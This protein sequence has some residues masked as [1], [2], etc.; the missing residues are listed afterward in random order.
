MKLVDYRPGGAEGK[1]LL[2]VA[3]ALQCAVL[4]AVGC[5]P[6]KCNAFGFRAFAGKTIFDRVGAVKTE[7]TNNFLREACELIE[8]WPSELR[9]QIYSYLVIEP[10]NLISSLQVYLQEGLGRDGAYSTPADVAE[11]MWITAGRPQSVDVFAPA[12]L[13]LYLGL[14][15][16][17]AKGPSVRLVNQL[18]GKKLQA[19]DA[20]ALGS[21][22]WSHSNNSEFESAF[23][24]L[25]DL[26]G[27]ESTGFSE[28]LFIN[29]AHATS[30][31]LG[32]SGSYPYER[33]YNEILGANY[34]RKLMLV[35]NT[36]LS[37]GHGPYK[38]QLVFA[39]LLKLGLESVTEI[40]GVVSRKDD[41]FSFLSLGSSGQSGVIKFEVLDGE[42]LNILE[43]NKFGRIRR[44]KALKE[45][46]GKS[47]PLPAV[48]ILKPIDELVDCKPVRKSFEPSRVVPRSE[49][50]PPPLI[51]ETLKEACSIF[52]FQHLE[53]DPTE[54]YRAFSELGAASIREY[55]QI[56][57]S[58]VERCFYDKEAEESVKQNAL[59]IGDVVLCVKGSIGKVALIE[60]LP[61][62]DHLTANQSFV[63][64][65][66]NEHRKREGVTPEVL[67]WWLR[68]KWAQ[69][70][71][72]SKIVAAGVPRIPISDI[73]TMPIP[74][75]PMQYLEDQVKT[76]KTW[77][78]HVNKMLSSQKLADDI[79]KSSWR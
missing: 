11:L 34:Q 56:D 22:D 17:G 36:M 46:F 7:A 72:K 32:E 6:E 37:A 19:S 15:C 61:S 78:D 39:E 29:A 28:A 24:N 3:T 38:S 5:G 49:D 4:C 1:R 10:T 35:P 42:Q 70:Y 59:E 44:E 50:L 16:L 13:A 8:K 79:Q 40:Q 43:I 52:R 62:S 73:E 26:L 20:I 63:R 58:K 68:S 76:Y 55:G 77:K 51:G 14:E 74:V 67:F 21:S 66:L 45:G 18:P 41:K 27:A 48:A 33:P 31:I 30:P 53:Q 64:L 25:V 71:L 12:G 47:L 57:G 54:T 75:G 2:D 65:R 23:E 69:D 60:E 9:D